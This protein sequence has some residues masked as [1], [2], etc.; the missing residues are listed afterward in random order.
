MKMTVKC[1]DA[2][3]D[4]LLPQTERGSQVTAAGLVIHGAGLRALIIYRYCSNVVTRML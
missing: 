2:P 3:W 4:T 1:L